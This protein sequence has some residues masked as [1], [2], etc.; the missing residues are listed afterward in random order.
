M[1][2][3]EEENFYKKNSSVSYHHIIDYSLNHKKLFMQNL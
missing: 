1:E 2:L 3:L